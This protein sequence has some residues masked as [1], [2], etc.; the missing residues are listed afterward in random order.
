MP[1]Y[2]VLM[3]AGDSPNRDAVSLQKKHLP[4]GHQLCDSGCCGSKRAHSCGRAG[5]KSEFQI[6]SFGKTSYAIKYYSF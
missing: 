6:N 5:V 4:E 3:T 2:N 1:T